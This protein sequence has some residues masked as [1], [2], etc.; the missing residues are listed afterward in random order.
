MTDVQTL[1]TWV[2]V[3]V[4]KRKFDVY[5]ERPDGR[6][7]SK[8]FPNAPDGFAALLAWGRAQGV[9]WTQTGVC[10]E[11]TGPYG[12]PL[13][14]ALHEAGVIVAIENPARIQAFARLLG[15]RVKT[16]RADARLMPNCR[17]ARLR[18]P[19]AAGRGP[20]ERILPSRGDSAPALQ[21][22]TDRS[23]TDCVSAA[24]A[25]A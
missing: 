17:A 18:L 7:R 9:D 22:G 4:S 10:L 16:D 11:A 14:R 8:V 13:A 24:R 1:S 25:G 20:R 23:P 21:P 15:A 19:L 12:R 3:D 5:V 6:G 2:G